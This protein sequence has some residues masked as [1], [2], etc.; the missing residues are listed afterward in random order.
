M[1]IEQSRIGIIIRLIKNGRISFP[2]ISSTWEGPSFESTTFLILEYLSLYQE[3][4]K[5][6]RADSAP[7]PPFL[8][9]PMCD[10]KVNR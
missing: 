4:T 10:L 7:A 2:F 8:W 6:S 5:N 9:H 3:P 1:G